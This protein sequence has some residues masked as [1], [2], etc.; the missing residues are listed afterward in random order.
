MLSMQARKDFL[1]ATFVV[2][3][4]DREIVFEF[5]GPLVLERLETLYQPGYVYCI[6]FGDDRSADL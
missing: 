5:L 4:L 2:S 6:S 3:R 1:Y